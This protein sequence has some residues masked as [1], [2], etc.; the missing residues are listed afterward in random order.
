VQKDKIKSEK[1]QRL[2]NQKL[3]ILLYLKSVKSHPPVEIIYQEVKKALPRI[4]MATVY[5]NLKDLAKQ[6]L[7]QE[8]SDKTTRYDGDISSHAHFICEKCDC[9]IDIFGRCSLIKPLK[10]KVGKIKK[11][12]IYFYGLCKKCF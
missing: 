1:K 11:H 12:Q 9:I 2:T 8:I 5:R 6:G 7:I 10:T 4:S 3:A